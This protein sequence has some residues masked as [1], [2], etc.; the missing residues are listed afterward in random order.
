MKLT[1][2]TIKVLQEL[3]D[4]SEV[5]SAKFPDNVLLNKLK[6][7]QIVKLIPI[8]KTRNKVHLIDKDY[9]SQYLK[10]EFSFSITQVWSKIVEESSLPILLKEVL[11]SKPIEIKTK[12]YQEIIQNIENKRP[13]IKKGMTNRQISSILLWGL[14]KVL[15]NKKEFVSALGGNSSAVML[16]ACGMSSDFSEILFIENYDT[17]VEYINK[18]GLEKYVIIY[19][20]GFSTSALRIRERK[21]CSLHYFNQNRLDEKNCM[22]FETWLYKESNENIN[23]SFFGDFDFS[24]ISIFSALRNLFSEIVMYKDGYDFMLREVQNDNGHLP[25]MA[26]KEDQKD[27]KLVNDSYCDDIL[28]PAMRKYGFFDQEGYTQ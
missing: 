15:D 19:S 14:S 10:V 26:S 13:L 23:T 16:N 1:L 6:E 11:L 3:Y 27:P 17:Y 8:G 25:E 28:L 4:K 7:N 9:L 21:S 2:A 20:A 5:S 12:S 18:N 22:R 24:G